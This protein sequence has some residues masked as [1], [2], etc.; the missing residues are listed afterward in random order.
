M[1]HMVFQPLIVLRT[2]EKKLIHKRFDNE[3]ELDEFIVWIR[4]DTS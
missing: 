3:L 4:Y 2:R 1:I